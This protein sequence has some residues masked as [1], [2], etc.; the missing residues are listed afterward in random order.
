[1]IFL[2]RALV[3][4]NNYMNSISKLLVIRKRLKRK[5]ANVFFF[6]NI[7]QIARKS[8]FGFKFNAFDPIQVR[9]CITEKRCQVLI[10]ILGG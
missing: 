8:A 9:R 1:M 4:H 6:I 10:S 7:A 2:N 5:G 3:F